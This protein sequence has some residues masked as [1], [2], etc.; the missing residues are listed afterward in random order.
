MPL[1]FD[2][3]LKDL[4]RSHPADWLAILE[5]PTVEPIRV[6]TPDLSTVS[7]FADIVF[8]LGERILHIDFQSGGDIRLPRR[9]LMYN[10]LLHDEYGLP[11]HSI[12]VLLHPRADRT[13][14]TGTVSYQGR[15]GRGGLTFQFEIV[16]LWQ[17]PVNVLLQS[18]LGTLPLAPLGQAPEGTVPE[19]IM[20]GAIER[21]RERIHS[22]APPSEV[23][24]LLTAAYVLTGLRFRRGL[25]N[26]FFQGESAMMESD[27]YLYILEQGEAKGGAK[28]ARKI[29]LHLGG[30]RLGEADEDVRTAVEAISDLERL[31]R[32]IERSQ[33]TSTWQ[34]VLQTP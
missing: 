32:M 7:A 20:A 22:E 13:D 2:A 24:K 6:L 11:V 27:T 26:Q 8:S 1:R 30:K 15:P 33:E 19:E 34:E 9:V 4:V 16:R 14:L 12:V 25:T 3:T 21:L 31:E 5:E 29:L 23:A 28:E 17:V 10:T 18:G